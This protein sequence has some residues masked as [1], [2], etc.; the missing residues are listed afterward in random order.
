MY[1]HN[2][3]QDPNP[4]QVEHDELFAAIRNGDVISDTEDAAKSTLAAI[5]GRMATYSG[6]VITW[7]E[8]INSQKVLVP[9]NVDWD[10]T[11]PVLPDENG[12]YPIP[13]PGEYDPFSNA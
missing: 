4:Y 3:M 13:V 10:T 7:D 5:M 11:P 2:G 9:E 12:R 8:A 6:K 1:D